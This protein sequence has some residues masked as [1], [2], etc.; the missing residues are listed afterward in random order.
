VTS[1]A[2]QRAE[3]VGALRRL[4]TS[5]AASSTAPAR[6]PEERCEL[7][8]IT[9]PG[10]HRHLL[11]LVERRIVCTCATCW[12]MRSGD[13]EF[14]PVGARTRWLE[15]LVVPDDVWARFSIPIGLAFFMR[16]TQAENVVALYPSPAGA[17][18]CEL[19]LHA[20]EDLV[21]L[22]PVL[23]ELEADA[24]GLIVNRMATPPAYVIAPIDRC[25]ALVGTVK[26]AWQGISGGTEMEEAVAAFFAELTPGTGR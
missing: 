8:R 5:G 15:D 12:S 16:S 17:T 21:A 9:I 25:Y 23:E 20:W 7:C 3:L 1:S 18:E 26:A 11:H 22:N 19:D 13:S 2:G 24:E 4:R 14:R 10:E 6:A